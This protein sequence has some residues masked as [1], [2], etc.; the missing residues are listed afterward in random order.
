MC[1]ADGAT[2]TLPYY[3][4]TEPDEEPPEASD[5]R[6]GRV[7]SE[8]EFLSEFDGVIGNGTASSSN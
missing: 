8:A 5:G 3:W 1:C 7:L 6:Y 4:N 2:M